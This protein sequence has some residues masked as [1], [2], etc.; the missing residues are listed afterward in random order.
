[1]YFLNTYWKITRGSKIFK[2]FRLYYKL[3]DVFQ[4]YGSHVKRMLFW[5]HLA[6]ELFLYNCHTLFDLFYVFSFLVKWESSVKRLRLGNTT[7]RQHR[8]S[9][10]T[11]L[12]PIWLG[13]YECMKIPYRSLFFS[14]WNRA[15][16]VDFSDLAKNFQI[17]PCLGVHEKIIILSIFWAV[18]G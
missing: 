11:I 7:G 8:F 1:M 13:T 4:V 6:I 18:K 17:W 9:D 5:W 12:S 16:R 14:V 2:C 3:T 15:S 10:L